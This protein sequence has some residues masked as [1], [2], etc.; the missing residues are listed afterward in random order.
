MPE[1]SVVSLLEIR[2]WNSFGPSVKSLGAGQKPGKRVR[3]AGSGNPTCYNCGKE[4][5]F[6]R[7]CPEKE[8]SSK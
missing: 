8:K 3:N 7:E 1:N 5:H 2:T 6:K 4:G